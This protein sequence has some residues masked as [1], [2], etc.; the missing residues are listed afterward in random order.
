[1]IVTQRLKD[2]LLQDLAEENDGHAILDPTDPVAAQIQAVDDASV[3]G[4]QA[5]VVGEEFPVHEAGFEDLDEDEDLVYI[6]SHPR[7]ILEFF[8][9]SYGPYPM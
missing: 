5:L 6:N 1:M 3:A 8:Y 7:T 4:I 2:Q 9:G